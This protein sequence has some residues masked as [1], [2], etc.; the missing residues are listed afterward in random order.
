MSVGERI[1]N[2]LELLR[3]SISEAEVKS[4]IKPTVLNKVINR[5]GKLGSDNMERFLRTFHV[6]RQWLLTGDG[7]IF[8]ESQKTSQ[9]EEEK[10]PY[11]KDETTMWREKVVELLEKRVADYEEQV[12]QLTK[13]LRQCQAEKAKLS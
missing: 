7:P 3:L 12:E 9:V 11:K 2:V 5:K 6:E 13:E 4:G 8:D 10:V 1:A